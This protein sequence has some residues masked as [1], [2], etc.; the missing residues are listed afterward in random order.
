MTNQPVYNGLF[1]ET[2]KVRI[3]PIVLVINWFDVKYRDEIQK[4]KKSILKSEFKIRKWKQKIN[5]YTILI[6]I[7]FIDCKRQFY[8]HLPWNRNSYEK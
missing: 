1:E 6:D 5:M 7:K 3:P 4:F 8:A 2:I